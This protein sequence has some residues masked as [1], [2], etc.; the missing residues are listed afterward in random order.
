M[1]QYHRYFNRALLLITAMLIV[2]LVPASA[3]T[4]DSLDITVDESG[5]AIAIFRFTLEGFVENAIPQSML[6]QELLKGLGTS[7]DPPELISMDRS[8]ATIRMRKFAAVDDVPTG[9]RFQ[10]VTM[11]F[12]KAQI[13]L[14]NSALSTVV[15]A[16]FSPATMKV[17]FP[18][19]YERSFTDSDILPSI[20][21]IIVD[22][23]KA[24]LAAVE[25]VQTPPTEGIVR[26]LSL[27]D[28]V[29]VTV[30]G[31]FTGTAPDTFAGIPA[32][33]HTFRFSKDNYVPVSREIDV[34]AGETIQVSVHLAVAEPEPNQAPGFA[35]V[36]AGTALAGCA[37]LRLRAGRRS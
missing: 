36:L 22:P 17:R 12:N 6:E 30:D 18:D 33:P 29:S 8:T 28:G 5:D 10:T 11:N 15:S 20:T 31:E 23:A 19:A 27:P 35:A 4:A 26:V 32:G 21:H 1:I 24:A 16:D 13:A 14:D 37:F 25:A 2:I 34:H 3:F 7:S 9:T